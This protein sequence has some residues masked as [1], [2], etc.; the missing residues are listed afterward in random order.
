MSFGRNF[1]LCYM[2][3]HTSECNGCVAS[4]S[5]CLLCESLCWTGLYA[6]ARNDPYCSVH[7]SKWIM[8]CCWDRA[9]I[10]LPS[11]HRA[12]SDFDEDFNSAS[13]I[14]VNA[15]WPPCHWTPNLDKLNPKCG[16][17]PKSPNK[18]GLPDPTQ[19]A[20]DPKSILAWTFCNNKKL[21]P[22]WT[23]FASAAPFQNYAT[24]Y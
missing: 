2:H 22:K 5:F 19:K 16:K 21:G 14:I 6:V 17:V 15:I 18:K 11:S 10:H 24:L 23:H 12:D 3:T 1:S 8:T 13:V 9:S 20:R 4:L 7:W